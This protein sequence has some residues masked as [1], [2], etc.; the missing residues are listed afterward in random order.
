MVNFKE[1]YHFSSFRRGSK[2][3]QGEWGAGV[4]TTFSGGG[5][6]GGGRIAYSL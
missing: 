3:V 1:K 6:G 2:F 5:G 4:P